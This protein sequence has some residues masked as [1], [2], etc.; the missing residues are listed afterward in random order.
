MPRG[1]LT[2]A[3]L[4]ILAG[5]AAAVIIGYA[6]TPSAGPLAAVQ[7]NWVVISCPSVS[8]QP[9]RQLTGQAETAQLTG[10]AETGQL[11]GRSGT[12]ATCLTLTT[13]P[14]STPPGHVTFS[15]V[16]VQ[17][18]HPLPQRPHTG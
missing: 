12:P 10:Q 14:A 5:T 4:P 18:P 13:K 1:R 6:P 3:I 9:S 11:T 17:P 15:L 7:A 16:N 8:G 2:T